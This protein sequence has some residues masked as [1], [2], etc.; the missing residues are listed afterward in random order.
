M[1]VAGRMGRSMQHTATVEEAQQEAWQF[2][3]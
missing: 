3:V 1:V 2:F